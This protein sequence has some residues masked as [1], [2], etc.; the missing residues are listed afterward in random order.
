MENSTIAKLNNLLTKYYDAVETG[1]SKTQ[2]KIYH[3]FLELKKVLKPNIDSLSNEDR[4]TYKLICS[5]F[6]IMADEEKRNKLFDG[7]NKFHSKSKTSNVP[8]T[9]DEYL[10]EAKQ[11]SAN[12]TK[13]LKDSLT[14]LEEAKNIGGDALIEIE[15]DNKKIQNIN[16]KLD[17]IESDSKIATKLITRFFKRLYTDKLIIAFVFIIMCLIVII[18][19][20]KY[21]VIV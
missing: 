3:E 9:N 18:F 19:L 13:K 16:N 17:Q 4:K 6:R 2:E 10:N 8:K 21:D 15:I 20:F 5:E 12:T 14:Q 11:I 1:S 7:M